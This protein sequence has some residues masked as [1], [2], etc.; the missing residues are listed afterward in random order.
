[1][2]AQ[3]T[4]GRKTLPEDRDRY[5]YENYNT[6]LTTAEERDFQDWLAALSMQSGADRGLDQI[7][8]DMRAAYLGRS[9]QDGRGHMGDVGKKP[10]HPT[11]SIESKYSTPQQKGGRWEEG[12][13]RPSVQHWGNVGGFLSDYMRRVEPGMSVLYPFLKK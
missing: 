6:P 3:L 7:D 13:F 1:M 2:Y 8:Y 9:S 12:G 4:P 10:N 5:G 11:F